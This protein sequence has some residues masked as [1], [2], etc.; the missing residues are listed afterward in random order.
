[1][2]V[3]KGKHASLGEHLTLIEAMATELG[4]KAEE[5]REK[6]KEWIR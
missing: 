6:A 3:Q 5:R 1:M 2:P 4:Q